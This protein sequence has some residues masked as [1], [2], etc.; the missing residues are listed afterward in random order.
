MPAGMTAIRNAL[1]ERIGQL[2]DFTAYPF[3]PDTVNAPGA[4][5]EPDR[6]FV[7]YIQVFQ[8]GELEWKFMVTVLVN[9]LDEPSAQDELDSYLDPLGPFVT[10][11][12]SMDE[13]DTL[14]DL[15]SYVN[16]TAA[17]RY[18]AYTIGGTTYLGAQMLVCVRG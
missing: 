13:E 10:K 14:R 18:G 5:V 3:I 4:F 7:D 2:P 6:P 1:V 11:L 9:R 12:Q 17:T 8:T 15:V 16:V